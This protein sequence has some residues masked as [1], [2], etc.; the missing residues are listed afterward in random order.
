MPSQ[1]VITQRGSFPVVFSK[2]RPAVNNERSQTAGDG[3]VIDGHLA[4]TG[5]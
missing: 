5:L 4:K 3:S 2:F 1:L